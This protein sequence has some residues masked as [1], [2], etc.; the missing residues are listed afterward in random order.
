MPLLGIIAQALPKNRAS[1]ITIKIRRL[2][3]LKPEGIVVHLLA[4]CI[5]L[6]RPHLGKSLPL[7]IMELTDLQVTLYLLHLEINLSIIDR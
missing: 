6:Y 7:L 1:F 4:L 2:N 5:Q 3:L